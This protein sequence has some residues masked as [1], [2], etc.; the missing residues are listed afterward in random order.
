[1]SFTNCLGKSARD[2][3]H[4]LVPDPP[5]RITG[6]SGEFTKRVVTFLKTVRFKLKALA[7]AKR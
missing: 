7:Q 5:Q 1:V 4:S 6:I 2:K 3:G